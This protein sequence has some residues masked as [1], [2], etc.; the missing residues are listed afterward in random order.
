M[1]RLGQFTE[2][3]RYGVVKLGPRIRVHAVDMEL[4]KAPDSAL[5]STRMGF[6]IESRKRLAGTV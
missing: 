6:E 1:G 5:A 2:E 3:I 4:D